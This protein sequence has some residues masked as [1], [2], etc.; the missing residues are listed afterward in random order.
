MKREA[1]QRPNRNAKEDCRDWPF[2]DADRLN[3]WVF[4]RFAVAGSIFGS[5]WAAVAL[6]QIQEVV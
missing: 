5:I 3:P 6:S 1:L 4:S 2:I